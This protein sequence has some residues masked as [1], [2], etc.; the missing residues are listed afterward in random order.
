MLGVITGG[1]FLTS[2]MAEMFNGHALMANMVL[3]FFIINFVEHH[4]DIFSVVEG[5]EEPFFGL[6]F[7]LAGTHFDLKLMQAAGLLSVVITVGRFAGKI[8][9]SRFGSQ[10]SHAPDNVKKYLGYAL[11]PT[12]GVT[13]G[14]V[15]DAQAYLGKAAFS[16]IMLS[17][18]LGS[19]LIN[20]FITP[21]L[22]KHILQ[23]SGETGAE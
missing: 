7:T 8:F 1:I 21:F 22:V 16:E 6:F 4:N 23:K 5:I 13:V 17:G 11:L 18:V 9:G 10:V 14:L 3:G 20:E 12:A 2:G 15:F 19:V